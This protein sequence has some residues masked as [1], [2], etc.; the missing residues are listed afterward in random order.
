MRIALTLQ[1]K[2]VVRGDGPVEPLER[3]LADGLRVDQVLDGVA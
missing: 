1:T 2:D 3:E